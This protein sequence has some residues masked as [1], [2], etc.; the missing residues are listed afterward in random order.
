SSLSFHRP[1]AHRHL[2]SFPTRRSSDLSPLLYIFLA[3]PP[4]FTL[5]T[6]FVGIGEMTFW[7]NSRFLILLAPLLILLSSTFIDRIWRKYGSFYSTRDEDQT[8]K[9]ISSMIPSLVVASLFI[10]FLAVSVF[11]EVVTYLDAKNGFVFQPNPYS[12]Q[13]GEALKSIYDGEGKIMMLTGS[14]QE[15]RIMVFS[16]IP[17]VQFDEIIE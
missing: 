2:H 4:L 11:G 14:A 5:I 15:H 9:P 7:F 3:L 6:L 12:V 16:G 10:Y 1:R 13:T 17:L 8:A